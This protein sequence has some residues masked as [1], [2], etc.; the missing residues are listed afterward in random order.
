M[1]AVR[2]EVPQGHQQGHQQAL[3]LLYQ[4][5]WCDASGWT[6]RGGAHTVCTGSRGGLSVKQ[7]QVVLP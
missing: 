2:Q 3:R 5:R 6:K 1:Q 4:L 7:Q